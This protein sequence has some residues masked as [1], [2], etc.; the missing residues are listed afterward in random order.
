MKCKEVSNGYIELKC[1]DC[2]EMKKIGFTCK[3]RF[4]IIKM[5]LPFDKSE[6]KIYTKFSKLNCVKLNAYKLNVDKFK[7]KKY[8]LKRRYKK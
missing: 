4:C 2:G 3:S 1:H 8:N 6:N 5:I 7:V